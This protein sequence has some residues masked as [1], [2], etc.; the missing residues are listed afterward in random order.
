MNVKW[1]RYL[2]DLRREGNIAMVA[3]LS[4]WAI[5]VSDT[6]AIRFSCFLPAI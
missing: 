1:R 5:G 4:E 3:R 2:A 6:T